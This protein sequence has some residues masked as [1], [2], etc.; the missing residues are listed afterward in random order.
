MRRSGDTKDGSG[1]MK[2]LPAEEGS[3]K[4]KRE[5]AGERAI[6]REGCIWEGAIKGVGGGRGGITEDEGELWERTT[7]FQ[8][9]V[10]QLGCRQGWLSC[11]QQQG[12]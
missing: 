11:E 10:S 6:L 2:W 9:S 4:A 5:G 7:R 3:Q 1:E 12:R 8:N